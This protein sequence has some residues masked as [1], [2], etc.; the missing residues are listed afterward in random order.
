MTFN[1]TAQAQQAASI[2]DTYI[3]QVKIQEENSF[4]E[5][6]LQFL[7]WSQTVYLVQNAGDKNF[8][9]IQGKFR[10]PIQQATLNGKNFAVDQDGKFTLNIVLI[11]DDKKVRF[12]IF[13]STQAGREHKMQYTIAAVNERPVPVAPSLWRYSAG[14]GTTLINFRQKKVTTFDQWA[15]TIKA[16]AT[17]RLV[18]N[19]WDLGASVFY[20]ALPIHSN[21]PKLYTIQYLGFNAKASYQLLD[22]TSRFRVVL[23]GG[24]YYNSSMSA[25]GFADMI[26]PQISPELTYIF[27]NGNSLFWYGKFAYSLVGDH[28]SFFDDNREVAMGLHYSYP[29]SF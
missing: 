21:S 17:Y 6:G 24:F 14:L 9:T 19:R 11:S 13:A 26:G 5:D 7:K 12:N 8:V 4:D 15:M 1:I 23:S 10:E 27:P 28:S 18:P 16:G 22:L 2:M 20:N 25:V 3:W 29:I